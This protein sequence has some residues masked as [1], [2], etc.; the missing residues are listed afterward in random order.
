MTQTTGSTVSRD[1]AREAM[2]R[3]VALWEQGDLSAVD[4]VFADGLVYHG[5]PFPDMDRGGL[6]DFVAAFRTA[7]TGIHVQVHEDLVDGTT[8]VHRWTA[9]AVF[10]GTTTLLPGVEPTGNRT[11]AGGAHLLHWSGDRVSEAWHVGDWL[12]WLTGAGVL[13]ALPGPGA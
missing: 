7:F 2:L 4:E 11:T 10:S 1:R 3:V 9:E 12:G 6:R 8:S 13:P 5:P